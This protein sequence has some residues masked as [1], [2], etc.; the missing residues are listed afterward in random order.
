MPWNNRVT[1][2]TSWVAEEPLLFASAGEAVV[3]QERFKPLILHLLSYDT[4]M[5]EAATEKSAPLP[6]LALFSLRCVFRPSVLVEQLAS[7][8]P[9]SSCP[10]HSFHG[11]LLT[12][13]LNAR[14]CDLLVLS[15][16]FILLITSLSQFPFGERILGTHSRGPNMLP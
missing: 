5:A 11:L 12:L 16:H 6:F 10:L 13:I 4:I 9:F 3:P 8:T 7:I 1:L 15:Y 14:G 2:T